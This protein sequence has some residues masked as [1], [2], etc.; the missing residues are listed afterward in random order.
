MSDFY[1]D[2]PALWPRIGRTADRPVTPPDKQALFWDI[3]TGK[4]YAV[5]DSMQWV[6]INPDHVGMRQ[7]QAQF[8]YLQAPAFTLIAA[9]DNL[10]NTTFSDVRLEVTDEWDGGAQIT[11]GDDADVD[12]LMQADGNN[13]AVFGT[14]LGFPDVGA[15]NRDI[16]AYITFDDFPGTGGIATAYFILETNPFL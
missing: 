10:P 14:Y 1:V 12:R 7:K 2:Q 5:N 16:K 3:Q 6:V 11:I 4:M 13:P 8:S 15:G 9:A